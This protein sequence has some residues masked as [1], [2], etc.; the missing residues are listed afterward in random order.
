L[1]KENASEAGGLRDRVGA[2]KKFNLF[3]I[4]KMYLRHIWKRWIRVDQ[5]C[6]LIPDLHTHET[7]YEAMIAA[8]Y[9]NY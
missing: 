7:S 9:L 5:I 8:N 1:G 6:E 3:K 2:N 4:E